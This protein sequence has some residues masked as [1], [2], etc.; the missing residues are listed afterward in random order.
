MK[1]DEPT[2]NQKVRLRTLKTEQ[3]QED[4]KTM[5]GNVNPAESLILGGTQLNNLNAGSVYWGGGKEAK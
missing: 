3:V 1:T 4:L 2:Q 5:Q